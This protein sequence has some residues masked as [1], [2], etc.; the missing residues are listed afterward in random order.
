MSSDFHKDVYLLPLNS[1]LEVE[2]QELML[3]D[4]PFNSKTFFGAVIDLFSSILVDDLSPPTYSSCVK[5]IEL[6]F[7]RS[8]SSLGVATNMDPPHSILDIVS[9][10]HYDLLKFKE[11][12]STI[13]NEDELIVLSET[14]NISTALFPI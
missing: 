7:E 6:A 2:L 14:I 4:I 12:L 11:I 1:V 13:Q 9:S 3:T 8:L 10:L 5:Y